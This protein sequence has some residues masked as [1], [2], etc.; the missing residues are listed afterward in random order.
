MKSE[1]GI[2]YEEDGRKDLNVEDHYNEGGDA[3]NVIGWC[4]FDACECC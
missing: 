4:L 2:R 1:T 3:R